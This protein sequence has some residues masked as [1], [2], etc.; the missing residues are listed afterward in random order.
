MVL[1]TAVVVVDDV[2]VVGASVV[3]VVE[4]VVV[5]GITGS[6]VNASSG[7]SSHPDVVNQLS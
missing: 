7:T 5:V 3:V 4:D 2:V 6:V 1:G